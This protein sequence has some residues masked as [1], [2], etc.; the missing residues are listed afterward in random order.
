MPLHDPVAVYNAAN[1]WEAHV[2]C[3]LLH[4]AG[5]EASVTEDVSQVGVCVFGLMSELHKPQIWADRSA[6]ELV[7]PIL[8]DYEQRQRKQRAVDAKKR[9]PAG[10]TIKATCEECGRRSV[11]PAAQDGSVQDCPHC[12]VFMDV[13]EM[14]DF[15]A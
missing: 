5:I 12:G 13:G 3:N 8:D 1:N 11:F 15:E 10:A 4:D 14:P 2:I 6:I 9:A 7:K